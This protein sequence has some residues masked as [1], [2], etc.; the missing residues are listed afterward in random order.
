MSLLRSTSAVKMQCLVPSVIVLTSRVSLYQEFTVARAVTAAITDFCHTLDKL[1][2]SALHV[3]CSCCCYIWLH[4]CQFLLYLDT[5]V[6]FFLG[7]GQTQW[8]KPEGT[9]LSAPIAATAPADSAAFLAADAF[10]GPRPGY[11]YKQGSQGPGYYRDQG[12]MVVQGEANC[13]ADSF[14]SF[15]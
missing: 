13:M 3:M 10:S 5:D 12:P 7:A 14:H 1:S 6:L 4:S 15:S 2:C 11:V 9:S 8:A